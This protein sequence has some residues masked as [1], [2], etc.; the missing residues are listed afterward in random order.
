MD[1]FFIFLKPYFNYFLQCIKE[2]T[3]LNNNFFISCCIF[4]ICVLSGFV[5]LI[6][7]CAV[8]PR[9]QSAK[10][11]LIL[12][13]ASFFTDLALCL[14][15]CEF[16]HKIFYNF[17]HVFT[18]CYLK[19]LIL[20]V[21]YLTIV[22][23]SSAVKPING[24]KIKKT[25]ISNDFAKPEK[26]ELKPE[27]AKKIELNY[28]SLNEN[29]CD[30]NGKN[31]DYIPQKSKIIERFL[32]S[33]GEI[34]SFVD[35]NVAYIKKIIESLKVKDLSDEDKECLGELEFRLGGRILYDGKTVSELNE[36]LRFLV[37]K[38]A[39]YDVAL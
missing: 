5:T 37:K 10:P 12:Y 24:V 35:I 16:S 32:G 34:R 11:I 17:V 15:E 28:V 33:K 38:A 19:F 30:K 2:F 3:L 7:C 18:F 20:L 4:C 21:L 14:C 29:V 1:D 23:C 8:R 25:E 39:E 27:N 6:I 22:F 13:V 26:N 31:Y 9:K 36:L